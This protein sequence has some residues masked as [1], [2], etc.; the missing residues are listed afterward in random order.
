MRTT[1]ASRIEDAMTRL[2]GEN[3]DRA[4]STL[5]IV[6]DEKG[7]RESLRMILSPQHRVL[8]AEDGQQ[9]LEI[10]AQ[11][12]VEA[13]T[14]DLN[15]PGMKGD[16]LMR[17]IR[18]EH[19]RTEVVIIT[20]YGSLET[21]I[22][23]LRVG[24]FDYLTKPFDVV[25]VSGT[26]RRALARG[27]SRSRMIAFLRGVEGAL[28]CG[29]DHE[30]AIA[31]LSENPEVRERLA[32]A[33]TNP[34]GPTTPSRP[35]DLGAP[36]GE[37]LETL[38]DAIESRESHRR[39]HARRVA[40]L[41]GLIARRCGLSAR[42][43]EDLRI[44]S[45]LHDIGRVGLVDGSGAIDVSLEADF[46]VKHAAAGA[47]LIEPL[48]FPPSIADAIRHHHDRWDGDGNA[49]RP[50]RD[51]LPLAS[52]IIAIADAFDGLTHDRPYRRA[53]SHAQAIESLRAQAGRELDPTLLKELISIAECGDASDGP[54]LGLSF[55]PG[56]DPANTIAAATAWIEQAR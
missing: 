24:I 16:E 32:A 34:M 39:G 48:G 7:P 26:I 40:F 5:L 17:R 23:G 9:A 6:D 31:N 15:M 25:E 13:V 54:L 38:A 37:F 46:G 41:A 3:P 20:G 42:V 56:D 52:R 8:M 45:F 33:L 49:D 44:A 36:T 22:A 19:P 51:A 10:L 27:Q 47:K 11:E 2:E 35:G 14:I 29:D 18:E 21:A 53:S 28:Q 4:K 55:E 30:A 43:Q 50:C 1:L 12:D